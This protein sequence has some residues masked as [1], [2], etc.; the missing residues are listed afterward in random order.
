MLCQQFTKHTYEAASLDKKVFNLLLLFSAGAKKLKM[1]VNI[2]LPNFVCKTTVLRE[3]LG[4]RH[5]K[6]E[7]AFVITHIKKSEK[8]ILTA[9]LLG[10][11]YKRKW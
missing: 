3:N 7:L 11:Q 6:I 2:N 4:S 10:V 8:T 5:N 9:S 1:F